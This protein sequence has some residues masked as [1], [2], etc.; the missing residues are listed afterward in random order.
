MKCAG[1][2]IKNCKRRG[3]WAELVF[4]ARAAE[5]GLMPLRPWGESSAYDVVLEWKGEF[6]RV[7]VKSTTYRQDN[8]Y[9]CQ[10][11]STARYWPYE[12]KDIDFMAVYVIPVDKWYIIPAKVAT[13]LVGHIWLTPQKKGHKYE[14]FLEAWELLRQWRRK[15]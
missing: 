10:T 14:A 7:Q 11:R 13:K 6:M 2:Q 3:E 15:K 9:I 4:M 5:L 12:V 1:E 8:S